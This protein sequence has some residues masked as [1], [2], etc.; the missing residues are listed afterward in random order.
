MAKE[1]EALL[2]EQAKKDS[3][4]F[5]QLYNRYVERIYAYVYRLVQDAQLSEDLTAAVFEK[6]LRNIQRYEDRG[7]SFS[8]WLYRIAH[9]EVVSHMR[10][11]RFRTPWAVAESLLR[12]DQNV[13]AE[14]Q[15]NVQRDVLHI[16]LENLPT[17]DREILV[18]RFF[19][20]FSSRQV[21]EILGYTENNVN[22]RMHR[23]LKK[24]RAEMTRY[25]VAKGTGY[26]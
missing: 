4:A 14:V 12:S 23:A 20:G 26:V 11:Q 24:L 17:K 1:D 10:R 22:V 15:V 3:R 21:A 9:N 18:L 25:E 16:A 13:E 6:A 5:D 7:F 2:V 8:A 19:E